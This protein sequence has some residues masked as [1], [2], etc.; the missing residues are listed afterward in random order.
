MGNGAGGIPPPPTDECG[1]V[2]AAR[3]WR[4]SAR[5]ADVSW[6]PGAGGLGRPGR[7][8]RGSRGGARPGVGAGKRLW[9]RP[10]AGPSPTRRLLWSPPLQPWVRAP[11]WRSPPSCPC[12]CSPGCRCTAASWPPPSGS[13]S[14][15]ACW[16]RASSSSLSPYPSCAAG[17]GGRRRPSGSAGC[18][19]PP[20]TPWAQAFNNLENLVFGKGFQAK[21]FPESKC[22]PG[23]GGGGGGGAVSEPSALTSPSRGLTSQAL[24]WSEL[25]RG[26]VLAEAV[27]G[28][29]APGTRPL[30][31]GGAGRE[32]RKARHFVTFGPLPR[33]GLRTGRAPC[34]RPWGRSLFPPEEGTGLTL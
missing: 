28:A 24:S 10:G 33:G 11:R 5:R 30:A 9:P 26:A 6:A 17:G 8:R 23:V 3:L 25:R 32:G 22:E 31:R 18:L 16:A 7:G 15:G 14:R 20:L 29:D 13:P 2:G 21:I 34:P 19:V 12:C 1:G 27:G 4:S